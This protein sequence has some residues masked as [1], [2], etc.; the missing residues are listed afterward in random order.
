AIHPDTGAVLAVEHGPNGGDEVNHILPG[1]NYGWPVY[2]FGR[3][4]EGPRVSELP[5]GA[6]TEQPIVLWVPSIAPTGMTFYSAERIPAWTGNL[7]VGSG[8]R[9]QIP[10]TGGLERIVLNENMEELRR[11]SL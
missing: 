2:S 7:F 4:Y 9:G 10:R 8:R 6:D 11:E 5:V 1:R 3:S